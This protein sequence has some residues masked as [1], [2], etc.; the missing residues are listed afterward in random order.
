M[1]RPNGIYLD[2]MLRVAERVDLHDLL[3][4]LEAF[5]VRLGPTFAQ[6]IRFSVICGI[7]W[8]GGLR[9]VQ[10]FAF[11]LAVLPSCVGSCKGF[12]CR[13]LPD[14]LRLGERPAYQV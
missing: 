9:D 6:L 12:L 13:G 11:Y 10:D 3:E 1:G 8:Q 4:K 5:R 2:S 7:R 14:W